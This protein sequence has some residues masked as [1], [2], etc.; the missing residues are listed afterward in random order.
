MTNRESH[1]TSSWLQVMFTLASGGEA[2]GRSM[3]KL[4][5]VLCLSHQQRYF[6]SKNV[7]KLITRPFNIGKKA[8]FPILRNC[9]LFHV[10]LFL[11]PFKVVV[12]FF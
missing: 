12:F 1:E 4:D 7:L 6:M 3:K 2:P 5:C 10:T 8:F 11:S 9:C